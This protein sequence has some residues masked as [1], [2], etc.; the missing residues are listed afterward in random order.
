M[1]RNVFFMA[2][3]RELPVSLS[4]SAFLAYLLR[5]I[6]SSPFI[7]SDVLEGLRLFVCLPKNASS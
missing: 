6:L 5:N 7:F 4:P 1:P 2:A 3:V